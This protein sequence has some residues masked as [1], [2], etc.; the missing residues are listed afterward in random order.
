MGGVE[1]HDEG[2]QDNADNTI[3]MTTLPLLLPPPDDLKQNNNQLN[4]EDVVGN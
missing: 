1:E 3:T 2:R 4:W